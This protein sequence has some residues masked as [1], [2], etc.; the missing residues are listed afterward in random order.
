MRLH[1]QA[2][3]KSSH[4]NILEEHLRDPGVKSL[5]VAVAYVRY[6]GVRRLEK[7]IGGIGKRATV[8]AGVRNAV[9][10]HQG[11]S[12][13]LELGVSVVTVDTASARK[14]FHP[15]MYLIEGIERA[16]LIVGSANLTA[17]GMA[18]NVEAS[19]EVALDLSKPEDRQIARETTRQFAELLTRFPD[20]VRRVVSASDLDRLLEEG[21]LVDETEMAASLPMVAA[22]RPA[23]AL[24][25]M[26]FIGP[27]APEG[28]ELPKSIV[29][30]SRANPKVKTSESS[31]ERRPTLA[32][33][34]KPLSRRD[35][36]IP[37]DAG[38]THKTGSMLWKKGVVE[39]ID[40]QRYFREVVFGDLVWEKDRARPQ[41][42]RTT[43]D[44]ALVVAGVNHGRF[45]L[46]LSHNTKKSLRTYAQKNAVTSVRWPAA[47]RSQ[48]SRP[49][50][51]GRTMRL[52]RYTGEP[53]R[54][55][56]EID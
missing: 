50:L 27:D 11:L 8:Y 42:E 55:I 2:F 49:E 22:P 36:N 35:L 26:A 6:E 18:Q 17:G 16:H 10:S 24:K 14:I 32:W 46:T 19:L 5:L 34:S 4:A 41:Y 37:A 9:T 31:S 33:T 56:I 44:F 3:T 45:I 15:K 54:F 7:A 20:N 23:R 29:L 25:A 13:L 40:H 28:S 53:L 38:T 47:L 12:R 52:Y 43:G 30:S 21:R 1:L 51:L 39:G 48:I